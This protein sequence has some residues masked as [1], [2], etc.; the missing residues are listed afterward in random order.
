M[1]AGLE[2]AELAA[3][4]GAISY[5]RAGAGAAIVLLHGWTLDRRMWAPQFDALSDTHL[6]IAPDRRG[7]GRSSAPPDLSQEAD[8]VVRLLDVVRAERAV[9]V[10]MSQAGRVALDF[11]LRFADRTQG[12][13]LHGAPLGGVTPGPSDDEAIPIVEYA[14]LVGAGRLDEMKRRWRAHPLMRTTNAQAAACAEA[15]LADYQGRD[16]AGE[17]MA[18]VEEADPA[19]I[20]APALVITGALDTPWRRRAGDALA[21]KLANASRVEIE[22]AGHLCNLCAPDAYNTALTR[23]L[24]GL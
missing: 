5:T 20:A 21:S 13:V 11:A 24:S 23:F 22:G 2:N 4:D 6:L 10:G 17:S 18:V 12:L 7:F 19:R 9:I 16:L 14:A 1:R 8:D 3:D 15:M